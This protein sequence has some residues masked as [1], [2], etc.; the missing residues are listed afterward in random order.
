MTDVNAYDIESYLLIPAARFFAVDTPFML[1]R[2]DQLSKDKHM[3]NIVFVNSAD[4]KS[5]P[6]AIQREKEMLE[7]QLN[8]DRGRSGEMKEKLILIADIQKLLGS[9]V[10][11]KQAEQELLDAVSAKMDDHPILTNDDVDFLSS[12][13]DYLPDAR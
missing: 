2:V 8:T 7:T 11:A 6:D 4:K 5:I 3:V 12:F 1:N 10:H 13:A 9:G